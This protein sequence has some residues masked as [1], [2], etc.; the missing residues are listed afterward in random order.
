MAQW[1]YSE[2]MVTPIGEKQV[3]EA[4]HRRY[5]Q[6][7]REV[8]MKSTVL[9]KELNANVYVIHHLLCLLEE[10]GLVERTK[11][12]RCVI[13]WRTRFGKKRE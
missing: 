1:M 12:S 5:D 2:R 7:K 9:A 11:L 8:L 3:L 13:V 6:K 4:L 10:K